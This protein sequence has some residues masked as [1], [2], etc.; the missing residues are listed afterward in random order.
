MWYFLSTDA[1][2]GITGPV[3]IGC[4]HDEWIIGAFIAGVI[5]GIFL[6]ILHKKVETILIKKYEK[7][8]PKNKD[9]KE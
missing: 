7:E 9:K 5:V 2:G 3:E 1:A 4:N 8:S 6:H